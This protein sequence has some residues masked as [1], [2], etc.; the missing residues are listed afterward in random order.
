MSRPEKRY[1]SMHAEN[2]T[3]MYRTNFLVFYDNPFYNHLIS[4]SRLTILC[5]WYD[6]NCLFKLFP[7]VL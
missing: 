7:L 3:Y 1:M 5:I 2:S 4:I 6:W